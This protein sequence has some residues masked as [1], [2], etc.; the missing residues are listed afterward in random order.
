MRIVIVISAAIAALPQ[1]SSARRAFRINDYP[2]LNQ[3]HRTLPFCLSIVRFRNDNPELWVG[4]IPEKNLN[5]SRE[6]A[7]SNIFYVAGGIFSRKGLSSVYF[8]EIAQAAKR[9]KPTFII[10]F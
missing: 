7:V 9:P 6:T 1:H 5:A 3:Q 8:T 10:N 4:A 2:A